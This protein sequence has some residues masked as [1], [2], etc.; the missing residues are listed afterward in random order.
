MKK[1]VVLLAVVTVSAAIAADA[2]ESKIGSYVN[3]KLAPI[4]AKEQE[5]N[6][7]IEA[8]KK[9]DAAKKVELEKYNF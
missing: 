7:K 4:T 3:Q 6:S 2:A 9:A 1:L 8:Q 5:I